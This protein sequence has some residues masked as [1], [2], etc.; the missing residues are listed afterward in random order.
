[1]TVSSVHKVVVVI[2]R[3]IMTGHIE[4]A[5]ARVRRILIRAT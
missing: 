3:A 5:M 1:M 2:M 4:E